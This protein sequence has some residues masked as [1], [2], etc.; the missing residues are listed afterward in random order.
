MIILHPSDLCFALVALLRGRHAN[1]D[2]AQ[3]AVVG[4]EHCNEW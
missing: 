2:L 1:G 4:V 3:E